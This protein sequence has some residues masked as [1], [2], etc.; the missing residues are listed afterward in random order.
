MYCLYVC[1]GKA[2]GCSPAAQR[3]RTTGGGDRNRTTR[4]KINHEKGEG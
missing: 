4:W 3:V 1:I 2:E